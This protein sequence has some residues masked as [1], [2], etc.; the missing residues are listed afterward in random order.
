MLG[1]GESKSGN[2]RGSVS[3]EV[4][5]HFPSNFTF[6]LEASCLTKLVTRRQ[7]SKFK[8]DDWPHIVGLQLADPK[9]YVNHP[10]DKILGV[11]VYSI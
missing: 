8:I 2:S 6:K 1:V 10:I 3:V 9:F 7:K 4:Q 11:D 5:P